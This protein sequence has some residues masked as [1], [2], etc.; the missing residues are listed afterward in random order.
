[1]DL[2]LYKDNFNYADKFRRIV[3]EVVRLLLFYPF[4]LPIF[5]PWRRTVLRIFGASIGKSVNIYSSAKIWA[6]WN[7][8]IG[9]YSCLGPHVD[10]YNQGMITIGSNVVVSQKTYLCASSHDYTKLHFPLELHPISINDQTWIAADCF[11]GPGVKIG[12]GALIGAR[13]AVFS[14]VERWTIVG[15]NPAKVLG[16]REIK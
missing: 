7:L 9:D 16:K 2:S 8:R 3:W 13:S 12:E 10:C 1:M 15:G 14:D 4:F 5:K 11:I 6:P